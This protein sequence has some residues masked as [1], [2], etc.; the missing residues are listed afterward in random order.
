MFETNTT[1]GAVPPREIAIIRDGLAL[2]IL[3]PDN[4]RACLTAL[5][6]WKNCPSAAGRRRRIDGNNTPRVVDLRLTSFQSIGHYAVNIAFSDGHDRGVYPWSLLQS[7]ARR[8]QVEDFLMPRLDA[9][10]RPN[11]ADK[12]TKINQQRYDHANG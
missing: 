5:Q 11:A 4:S 8:K 6:L 2:Q 1:N 3:W 7:L 10:S 9:N 12:T